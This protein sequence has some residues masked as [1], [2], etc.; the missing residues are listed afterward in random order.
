MD[1]Q[2]NLKQQLAKTLGEILEQVISLEDIK[3][4]TP[5]QDELGD[6]AVYPSRRHLTPKVRALVDFLVEAFRIRAWPD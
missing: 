1:I 5:P 3:L 2:N 6:Y 4:S